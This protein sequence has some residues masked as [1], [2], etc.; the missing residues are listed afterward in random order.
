MMVE[1]QFEMIRAM[2]ILFKN[3]GCSL[4]E[5]INSLEYLRNSLVKFKWMYE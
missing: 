5:A 2:I 3:S 4:D 1:L